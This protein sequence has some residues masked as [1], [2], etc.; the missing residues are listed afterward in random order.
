MEEAKALIAQFTG[1]DA[2]LYGLAVGLA[3]LLRFFR[4]YWYGFGDR[5]TLLAALLFGGLGSWL[6][7]TGA[8]LVRT[9]QFL[10]VQG[11]SLAS[12][13]LLFE[14][15]LRKVPGLPKDDHLALAKKIVPPPPDPPKEESK[16]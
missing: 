5:A 8:E 2:S 3:V 1:L 16:P 14:L 12:A 15:A 7:L 10:V 13:V 9:P 6:G 4:S 11:L